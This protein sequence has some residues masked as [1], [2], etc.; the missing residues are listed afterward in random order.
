ML[1]GEVREVET[2]SRDVVFGLTNIHPEA[3]HVVRVE[4]TVGGDGGEDLFL[5]GCGAE[6]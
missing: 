4:L 5:D 2:G 3:L 1:R 6:L